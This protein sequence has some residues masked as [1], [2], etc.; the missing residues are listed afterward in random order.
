[1]A[2]QLI[3][4][5]GTGLENANTYTSIIDADSYHAA[6]GRTTWA[7]LEDD[8]KAAAL[9][10]A[11]QFV[12][13]SF[14]WCGARMF[15]VQALAWPRHQG[16][17]SSGES[18][19]LI[20]RDGWDIEGIPSAIKKAVAEAAFISLD[21]ELFT[22]ADP[23]GKIIRDK[24]DVLETEYQAETASSKPASPTIYSVINMMLRGLYDAP[25]GG[26]VVGGAFRG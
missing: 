12:D 17:D 22:V 14:T 5:D 10:K 18:I 23:N 20:D 2:I 4:E 9:I 7:E 21:A 13:A 1:M 6:L 25:S 24:T 26:F 8:E 3:V 15:R 19:L 16:L 11:T